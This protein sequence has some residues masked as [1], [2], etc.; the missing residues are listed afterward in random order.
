MH[1]LSRSYWLAKTVQR[2]CIVSGTLRRQII[3]ATKL[4]PMVLSTYIIESLC[5]WILDRKFRQR[6]RRTKALL[7][8]SN[9]GDLS[10][11]WT[12]KTP[13][14]IWKIKRRFHQEESTKLNF[15]S[16]KFPMSFVSATVWLEESD[17]SRS[18]QEESNLKRCKRWKVL[19]ILWVN[20]SSR[21]A[22]R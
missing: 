4:L 16:Y 14:I 9:F 2:N 11:V 7:D 20:N 18:K 12:P 15:E 5:G 3:H 8:F 22:N 1:L 6:M 17:S 21:G 10:K 13:D 19:Q